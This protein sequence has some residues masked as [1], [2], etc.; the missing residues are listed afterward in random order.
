[1]VTSIISFSSLLDVGLSWATVQR[2]GITH[3]Q[4]TALFWF[5]VIIGLTL[6]TLCILTA[7][8]I[9]QFYHRPDIEPIC[10]AWGIGLS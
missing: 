6:W 2:K 7:P 10:V 5:G 1:M 3:E 9:G 8:L 4:V